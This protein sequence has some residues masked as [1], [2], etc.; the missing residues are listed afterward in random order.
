[1]PGMRIPGADS[2]PPPFVRRAGSPPATTTP[3]LSPPSCW[4]RSAAAAPL[5]SWPLRHGRSFI[6]IELNPEYVALARQ[7]IV[8]DA[9]LLNTDAERSTQRDLVC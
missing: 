1:M 6:G 3:A 7:R 2:C 8:S 5:G 9:P 4:T